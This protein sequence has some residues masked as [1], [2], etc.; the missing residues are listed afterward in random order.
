M[1]FERPDMKKRSSRKQIYI[2]KTDP[3]PISDPLRCL[4]VL[5]FVFRFSGSGHRFRVLSKV[6]PDSRFDRRFAGQ[7]FVGNTDQHTIAAL[8]RIGHDQIQSPG[9]RSIDSFRTRDAKAG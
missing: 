4:L 1:T 6:S 7:L 5:L 8:D 9:R 2:Q 3:G